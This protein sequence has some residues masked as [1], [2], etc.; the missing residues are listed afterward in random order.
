MASPEAREAR[1]GRGG[2]VGAIVKSPADLHR[3]I[4]NAL[5]VLSIEKAEPDASAIVAT[6]NKVGAK[7]TSNSTAISIADSVTFVNG[8]AE[9]P[10][11]RQAPRVGRDPPI[12]SPA[13]KS[14]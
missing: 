11:S 4:A 10:K 9:N 3:S 14:P 8:D 6:S 5:E 1:R 7:G 12:A 13:A 2:A